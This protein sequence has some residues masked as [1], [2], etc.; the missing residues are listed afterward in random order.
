MVWPCLSDGG[1]NQRQRGIGLVGDRVT[2]S[3]P[4]ISHRGTAVTSRDREIGGSTG[5]HRHIV[6]S[7]ING[8]CRAAG[9]YCQKCGAG[10]DPGGKG[11][12]LDKYGI[13]ALIAICED[14]DRIRTRCCPPD[15]TTGAGPL[16]GEPIRI[17]A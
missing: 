2:A 13:I 7:T 1:G 12:I 10:G 15:D 11:I 9:D 17:S 4:L 16:V 3:I 8:G 6:R 14:G 5:C